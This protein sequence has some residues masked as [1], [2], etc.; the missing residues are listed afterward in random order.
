[1][2]ISGVV[3]INKDIVLLRGS[4]YRR[5]YGGLSELY[6]MMLGWR[7]LFQKLFSRVLFPRNM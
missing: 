1:M 4:Q 5:R 6:A 3:Q 2:P 7:H